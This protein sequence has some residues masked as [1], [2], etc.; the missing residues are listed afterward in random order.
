MRSIFKALLIACLIS[1]LVTADEESNSP[2]TNVPV[3]A[4]NIKHGR[5]MDGK[6]DLKRTA[7]T[8]Q[9]YSP[10]I[11][12]LQ[13]VDNKCGR[14]GGVDQAK[15]LGE[16]LG[17]HHA[18][19]KFMDY[20]GGE[21]G[22]GALSKYPIIRAEAHRLP[23]G[24]EPR[25]ALEIEVEINGKPVSFVSIHL[26]WT[27]E[28]L[29]VAQAKVLIEKLADREHP[30]VLV[31]DFNARR[32]SETLRLLSE[33]WDVLD[34]EEAGNTFPSDGPRIEIDFVMVPKG[35]PWSKLKSR[36]LDEKVT[37]DHCPVIV[38]MPF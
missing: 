27:K 34:K 9:K 11:V 24:A 28:E 4:Y 30:V 1:P 8:I 15:W 31:G 22:M 32:G 33:H 25:C 19:G 18:F 38:E 16:Q 10:A 7:E 36:V 6:L 2:A 35:S 23:D 12:A 5:G 3:M 14:S 29:R 21:Y 37:S 26:D 13:E 20:G 17:M